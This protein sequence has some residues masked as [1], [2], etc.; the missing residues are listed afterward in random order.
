[1]KK[2]VGNADS[3]FR[4]GGP[5]GPSC[6]EP[7]DPSLRPA[8]E[9]P[10]LARLQDAIRG[11]PDL[12]PPEIL[13]PSVMRSVR[14]IRLPIWIR[15][16]RWARSPR[17]ITFT[18]LRAFPAAAALI[19]VAFALVYH[20]FQPGSVSLELPDRSVRVVLVLKAPDA[21]RVAVIGSFNGWRAQDLEPQTLDGEKRWAVTLML[22]AGRHEYAFVVDGERIVPDPGAGFHEED[23]FGN[24]NAVLYIGNGNGNSI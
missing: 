12:D 17:S 5:S 20:A 16:A 7:G 6:R 19:A 3:E 8:V 22:P 10:E 14:T 1:M 23:G 13:L 15:F 9:E 18:P 21:R 11:M 2:S 4:V 24:H